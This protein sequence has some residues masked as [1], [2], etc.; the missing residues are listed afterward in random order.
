[1]ASIIA[2]SR[3]WFA[4]RHLHHRGTCV[5]DGY[6]HLLLPC[7]VLLP[8]E[9]IVWPPAEQGQG[10]GDD[11]AASRTAPAGEGGEPPPQDLAP[12]GVME[13]PEP[14]RAADAATAAQEL[15]SQP[16]AIGQPQS[17][18]GRAGAAP[19]HLSLAQSHGG[20]GVTS[21]SSC[22]YS[23][24]AMGVVVDELRASTSPRHHQQGSGG[25]VA[26]GERDQDGGQQTMGE[27]IS[28]AAPP[29]VPPIAPAPA[30]APQ[31]QAGEPK[32]AAEGQQVQDTGQ[33]RTE[34]T[35]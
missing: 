24:A 14:A 33:A 23:P 19:P 6:L 26:S 21:S 20:S 18:E 16:I 17:P 30:A 4:G 22:F 11:K 25:Q 8:Q 27:L 29:R 32:Q 7:S 12:S 31:P 1:M 28:A 5:P 15:G 2:S 10:Q 13:S 35:R 34:A 9:S 3:S